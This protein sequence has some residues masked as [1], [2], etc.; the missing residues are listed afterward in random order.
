MF[1]RSLQQRFKSSDVAESAPF[2]AALLD[3]VD[4][5]VTTG[6]DRAGASAGLTVPTHTNSFT[7]PNNS[8]KFTAFQQ[9]HASALYSHS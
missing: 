6:D 9:N 1:Q 2:A 8:N 4:K 7:A 3:D 5:Q